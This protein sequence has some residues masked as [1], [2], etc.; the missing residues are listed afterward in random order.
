MI[1]GSFQAL[2]LAAALLLA[3]PSGFGTAPS[4]A[5][6]CLSQNEARAAVAGGQASPLSYFVGG[7]RSMGQVVSSC[8]ARRGGGF[9]YVVSIVQANGQVTRVVIDARTGQM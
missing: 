7:L 9:V 6:N 4:Y 5:Q 8:L 1:R 3:G 2:F